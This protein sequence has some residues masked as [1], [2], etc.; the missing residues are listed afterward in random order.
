MNAARARNVAL[1]KLTEL[2]SIILE[3]IIKASAL[4]DHQAVSHW[5]KEIHSYQTRLHRY[6]KGK[7]VKPNYTKDLLWEYLWEDQVDELPL[8]FIEEYGLKDL[9]LDVEDIKAK[10]KTFIDGV[11]KSSGK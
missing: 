1:E 5:Q 10:L 9:K 7:G 4:S 2:R 6:H 3:H 11:M 8:G